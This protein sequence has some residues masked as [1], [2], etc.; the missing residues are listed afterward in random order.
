M[1]NLYNALYPYMMTIVITMAAMGHEFA[2]IPPWI[3]W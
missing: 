2:S 1:T 3:P